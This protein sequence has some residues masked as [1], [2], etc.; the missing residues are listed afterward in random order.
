MSGETDAFELKRMMRQEAHEKAFEIQV[1][2]Q[3]LYEKEKEKL[4]KQGIQ[5]QEEEYIKKISK[6]SQTLNIERSGKV[7]EARLKKM[8]ERNV[9]MDKIRGETKEHML[10]TVIN[11]ENITYRQ[12]IKNLIIQSMIKLL[13]KELLIRCRHEDIPLLR[14]LIPECE[15][16]YQEI[17]KREVEQAT[18]NEDGTPAH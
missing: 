9:C 13:E 7:N 4:V 6:L 3:R 15:E 14:E 17:M 12:A 2:T 10:R 1:Q 18:L 16:E 5:A 8:R 11:S